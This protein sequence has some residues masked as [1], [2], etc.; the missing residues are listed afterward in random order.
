M[1]VQELSPTFSPLF[2]RTLILD[3][4]Q[5]GIFHV[6]GNLVEDSEKGAPFILSE[7]SFLHTLMIVVI[8]YSLLALQNQSAGR[9]PGRRRRGPGA[10]VRLWR[11]GALRA[12]GR[13]RRDPEAQGGGGTAVRFRRLVGTGPVRG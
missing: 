1:G 12:P 10:P 9:A 2:M 7:V 11:P 6:F 4:D 3:T 8:R 5:R 13:R